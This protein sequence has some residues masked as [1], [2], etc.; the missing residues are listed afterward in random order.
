[1]WTPAQLPARGPRAYREGLPAAVPEELEAQPSL[2]FL[3]GP[4]TPDLFALPLGLLCPKEGETGR[5]QLGPEPP[6]TR[7]R[8][9]SQP[10]WPPAQ[11]RLPGGV[12]RLPGLGCCQALPATQSLGGPAWGAGA[13]SPRVRPAAPV[14]HHSEASGTEGAC[15]PQTVCLSVQ[16]CP[17]LSRHTAC[18]RIT[19]M[20]SP[21]AD[22]LARCL[23][24]PQ[25]CCPLARPRLTLGVC[26]VPQGVG[27]HPPG[28]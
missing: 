9:W 14:V 2:P 25:L 7:Q 4:K 27:G 16:A 8:N 3:W 13:R 11:S 1:M 23:G 28:R 6:R 18:P 21:G 12:G 10:S 15:W 20:S 24:P 19:K 22:V 5:T 26:G 17:L